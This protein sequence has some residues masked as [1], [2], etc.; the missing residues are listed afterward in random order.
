M[1]VY[2]FVVEIT[3]TVDADGGTETFYFS[4]GGKKAG[5][6]TKPTDTPA[7]KW[8]E[9]RVLSL[10]KLRRELFTGARVTGAIRP[11]GAT[12]VLNNE[13]GG[14]DPWLDYGVSGSRVVYRWGPDGGAYPADYEI[15]QLCYI[16]AFK[17]PDLNRVEVALRDRSYLLDKPLVTA[18][19][20]GAGGLEGT[21]VASK[22]KQWVSG[23]PGY[24]PPI[25]VDVTKQIYFIQETGPGAL[26][27][28]FQLFEGGVEI[29]R[30]TNY[31]SE[32]EILGTEP[33]PGTCRFWFGSTDATPTGPVYVRLG[34]PPILELRVYA[35]GYQS[36]GQA[37]TFDA[38]CRRAGLADVVDIAGFVG[39]RLVDDDST[40]L[41]VMEAACVERQQF[42]GFDRLDTFRAGSL[43][44]PVEAESSY[45]FTFD[46]AGGFA[47]QPVSGMEA[48]V[49]QVTLNAGKT[50]P[51]Q[52]ADA[53]SDT[54][55]DY[56]SRDPWW[57]SFTG[58]S[59]ATLTANPGAITVELETQNRDI[60]NTFSQTTFINRFLGL[61][62]GRRDFLTVSAKEFSLAVLQIELHD[63]V[64]VRIPRLQCT[65]GRLFRVVTID[66][67]WD[68]PEVTFG[69]WGGTAGDG[70]GI[71]TGGS[72]GT[73]VTDPIAIRSEAGIDL[74]TEA[75][76]VLLI[77]T[78][79]EFLQ[80]ETDSPLL[81][82][83]SAPLILE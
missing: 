19:F 39:A 27:S 51:C 57:T 10:G 76:E 15:V 74:L 73:E 82:E 71:D 6:R 33:S 30:G 34:T 67:N 53:A 78:S 47:R 80:T 41:Q 55:K 9:P 66:I 36:T 52:F 29:T 79:Y 54:M 61:F 37:W 56:L 1:T 43:L 18:T 3:L 75:G 50:F 24:F 16:Q 17:L 65:A 28:F 8:V 23:D 48:P 69:L 35:L 81:T 20:T 44:D 7:N 58:S 70:G 4:A 46:N 2:R 13:D 38:L 62:G 77:E 26:A 5:F 49:W 12:L 63:T 14:L 40:Y 11:A 72:G 60:Q 31:I 59:A 21:G 45:T 64:T 83:G 42:F 22:K 68:T 32:A 25:L